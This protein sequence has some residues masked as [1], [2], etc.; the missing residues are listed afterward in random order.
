MLLL[1]RG[2]HVWA[3]YDKGQTF[4]DITRDLP[5]LATNVYISQIIP[6]AKDGAVLVATNNLDV[7]SSKDGGRT[8]IHGKSTFG[9]I[10]S[11]Q[12][13]PVHDSWFA[14]QTVSRACFESPNT[15]SLDLHLT[16]DGGANFALL[17][18]YITEFSW[19][20]AGLNGVPE[21][22]L[23]VVDW[24]DKTGD[25]RSKPA[26]QKRLV[27]STSFFSSSDVILHNV[28]DF[29]Y[30]NSVFLVAQRGKVMGGLQLL[31]SEDYGA[32][33]ITTRFPHS[34]ALERVRI[35][36]CAANILIIDSPLLLQRYTILGSELGAVVINIEHEHDNWGNIYVSDRFGGNFS[37]S[38]RHNPVR[39]VASLVT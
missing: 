33:W 9:S 36:P 1:T 25:F 2:G 8:W 39:T 34:G 20:G 3:S 15:C 22:Q 16:T 13:H 23:L 14:V 11:L 26:D 35:L 29:L 37:L 38:L 27:R 12:T 17:T 31:I 21:N 18:T 24:A 4:R 19:G 28:I 7:W 6:T 10:L 32:H 30:L 5:G